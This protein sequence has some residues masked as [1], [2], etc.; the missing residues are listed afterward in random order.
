MFKTKICIKP[1]VAKTWN[2]IFK[3]KMAYNLEF[4]PVI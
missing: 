1:L 4:K 2:A 3:Q